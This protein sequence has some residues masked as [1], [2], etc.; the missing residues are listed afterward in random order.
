MREMGMTR[1]QLRACNGKRL[2]S[3]LTDARNLFRD[4][5]QRQK[6][7][8]C[9]H[10]GEETVRDALRRL[11]WSVLAVQAEQGRQHSVNAEV[12]R[13]IEGL[14]PV[15]TPEQRRGR[16][17]LRANLLNAASRT[18]RQRKTVGVPR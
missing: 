10:R 7:A 5:A 16:Q 4:P 8:A 6:L 12:R 14:V 13:M 17:Q 1:D 9:L 11:I 3:L 18:R 15:E 2:A